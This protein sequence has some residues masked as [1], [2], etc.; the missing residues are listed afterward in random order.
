MVENFQVVGNVY[1]AGAKPTANDQDVLVDANFDP[2]IKFQEKPDG[3][4][5]DMAVDPAWVSKQKRAI[6]TT[7]LLGKT[8][9]P[10]APFEQ[11]DGTSYR[12]DRDYFGKKRNPDN[13]VPGPFSKQ[14]EG[15]QLIKVW[16]KQQRR[17]SQ[18]TD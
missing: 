11:P 16:P 17:Y 12:L 6:V 7:E 13:P 3:W 18:G 10:D 14:K 8:K 9:I 5:L 2:C 1:L 15:K 4:R